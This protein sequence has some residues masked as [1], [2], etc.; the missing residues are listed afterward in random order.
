[1]AVSTDEFTGILNDLIE[2]CKDGE[3]GF[4]EAAEGITDPSIRSL[5]QTYAQ[6][7][8]DYARELQSE[9]SRL[10]STPETGG[11]ASG[12]LHRGW[13]NLKSAVTG[14]NDKAIV[15]EAER[16]EDVA[17]DQY[18]K[19]LAHDIPSDLKAVVTRQYQGVQEAHNQVRNLKHK[20]H[21]H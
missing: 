2:T 20:M 15:D 3:Q 10:G 17:V 16:G 9:V 19:A 14:K 21:S 13:I 11:S 5:F 12:A 6:Q 7:R 18:Q 4:R 8:A 1:M